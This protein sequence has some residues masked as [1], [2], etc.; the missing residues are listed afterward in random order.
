MSKA[1]KCDKCKKLISETH[2][3]D[4]I[5]VYLEDKTKVKV[6]MQ[7]TEGKSDYEDYPYKDLCTNCVKKILTEAFELL[8]EKIRTLQ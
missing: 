8:A 5:D 1:Y 2:G 6:F 4:E 3:Q 7:I